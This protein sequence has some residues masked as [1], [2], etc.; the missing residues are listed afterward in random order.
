[1]AETIHSILL[2][3]KVIF[4]LLCFV[5]VLGFLVFF[6]FLVLPLG[7]QDLGFPMRDP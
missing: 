6:F 7:L 4:I 3:G 2:E 5:A 1:M